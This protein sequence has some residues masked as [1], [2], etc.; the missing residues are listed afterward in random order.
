MQIHAVRQVDDL[1]LHPVQLLPPRIP[2]LLDE[3][4]VALRLLTAP[5]RPTTRPRKRHH[6]GVDEGDDAEAVV[7]IRVRVVLAVAV[8][9]Q[10]AELD[11][12]CVG[13]RVEMSCPPVHVVKNKVAPVVDE[14][15]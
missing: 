5:H 14:E 3:L 13:T 1:P 11:A 15:I 7:R 12:D 10:T 2:R 4:V 9:R 8:I 6:C